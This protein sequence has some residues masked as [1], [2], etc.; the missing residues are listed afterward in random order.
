MIQIII[1]DILYDRWVTNFLKK[2]YSLEINAQNKEK[3]KILFSMMVK[4]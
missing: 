4:I 1:E 3:P 2:K